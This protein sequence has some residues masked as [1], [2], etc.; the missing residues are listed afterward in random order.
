MNKLAEAKE[1]LAALKI[2]NRLGQE[3]LEALQYATKNRS[4]ETII[5]ASRKLAEWSLARNE[6]KERLANWETN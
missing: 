2:S 4:E 5:E 1:L 6:L 3:S